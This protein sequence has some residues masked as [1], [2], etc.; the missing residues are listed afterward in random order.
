MQCNFLIKTLLFGYKLCSNFLYCAA[1]TVFQLWPFLLMSGMFFG[2]VWPFQTSDLLNPTRFNRSL[3]ARS[4]QGFSFL[5]STILIT[6]GL[7]DQKRIFEIILSSW[8]L[9]L[10]IT[11]CEPKT[12]LQFTCSSWW[13]QSLDSR[14]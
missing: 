6:L 11:S 12:K 13:K 2:L 5:P 3:Q 14:L 7:L 8:L 1:S 10:V 4:L 9:F